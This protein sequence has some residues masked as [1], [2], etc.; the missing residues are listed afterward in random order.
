MLNSGSV[1]IF[2]AIT[3]IEQ[4]TA[5]ISTRITKKGSRVNRFAEAKKRS[6]RWAGFTSLLNATYLNMAFAVAI[7][8]SVFDFSTPETAS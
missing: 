1:G 8:G 5:S 2:F 3:V 7:N 6:F 4:I